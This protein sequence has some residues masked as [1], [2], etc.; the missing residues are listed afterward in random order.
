ML[1][2]DNEVIRLDEGCVGMGMFAK[3]PFVSSGSHAIPPGAVL[4]CFTDG[5]NEL[6]DED[7]MHY[8]D[9]RLSELLASRNGQSMQALNQSIMDDLNLHRGDKEFHDDICLISCLFL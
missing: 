2:I 1:C 9:D 8:M 6:E 7:G 4:T 5:V 3:L